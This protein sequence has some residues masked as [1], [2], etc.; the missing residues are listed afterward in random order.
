[1]RPEAVER[2]MVVHGTPTAPV[3][4]LIRLAL[5]REAA[6]RGAGVVL[7]GYDGDTTVNYGFERLIGLARRG[8]FV[9]LA[10]ETLAAYRAAGRRGLYETG[11]LLTNSSLHSLSSRVQPPRAIRDSLVS[12]ALLE[13]SGFW[14]RY[15]AAPGPRIGDVRG[16]HTL[17]V[18]SGTVALA[19]ERLEVTALAAGVQ[20]RHP[21]FDRRLVEFC[22]GLPPDL[23][24]R[25]RMPRWIERTALEG[26]GPASVLWRHDKGGMPNGLAEEALSALDTSI[27][28][29]LEGLDAFV[30]V[31]AVQSMRVAWQAHR[32]P[33]RGGG[34]LPAVR[35]RPLAPPADALISRIVVRGTRSR[36]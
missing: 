6:A 4:D 21:F 14:D 18:L 15:H 33:D 36:K 16:E 25:E 35:V 11:V 13:R 17:D 5:W 7:D 9:T 1:M 28:D 3:M 19:T 31:E 23:L 30:D 20:V 27:D 34:A 10:N 8:R 29:P 2:L 12:P 24:F 26:F 32:G 22:I